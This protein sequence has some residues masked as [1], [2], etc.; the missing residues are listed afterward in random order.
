MVNNENC[1]II[2]VANQKGGVGKT[3]TAINFATALS[4]VEKKVLFIDFDPQGNGSTGFGIL[5]E[6][7]KLSSYDMV[8]NETALKDAEIPSSIPNLTLIPAVI[9]LS[10]ADVELANIEKREFILKQRIDQCDNYYDY[11]IIDCPPSLGLLTVNALTAATS[12]IIPLQCEFY[13]LEGLTHLL[14]TVTLVQENLNS[15]LS[16][17]GIVLTM[18]DRRNRLTGEV[19]EDVRKY[20]SDMVFD[21]VIPRNVKLSEAP[22]HGKP[23]IIYNFKCSGSQAYLH[24]VREILTKI[25]QGEKHG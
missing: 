9:D 8:I 2:A 3:T 14:K 21:T 16:I 6:N 18:Y 13:A 24:L 25:E 19:E 10:A 11:I 5:P 20:L 1:K 7:R 23:A 22:S 15:A 17:L 4:A 12:V